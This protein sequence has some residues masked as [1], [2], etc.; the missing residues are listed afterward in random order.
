MLIQFVSISV[1][2][3][4]IRGINHLYNRVVFQLNS[5]QVFLSCDNVCFVKL[6]ILLNMNVLET[7]TKQAK[8]KSGREPKIH[9][10][11]EV[12]KT[13]SGGNK[14][15]SGQIN[16]QSMIFD[17]RLHHRSDLWLEMIQT[18][19]IQLLQVEDWDMTHQLCVTVR[20]MDIWIIVLF[21]HKR[22]RAACRKGTCAVTWARWS[23]TG[24]HL[25]LW[26]IQS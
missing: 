15:S 23:Q 9:Q 3:S 22:E 25:W 14:F 6:I 26:S 4:W 10:V 7:P 17:S 20:L 19:C 5:I 11:T 1:E 8:W 16:T 12:K 18:L 24:Q 2:E 13:D 21:P